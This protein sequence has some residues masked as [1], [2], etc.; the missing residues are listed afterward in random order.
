M[1]GKT[2][3]LYCFFVYSLH[4]IIFHAFRAKGNIKKIYIQKEIPA[5]RGGGVLLFHFLLR[6]FDEKYKYS[7]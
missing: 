7:V 5:R 2:V 3:G 1:W 4:E 6:I